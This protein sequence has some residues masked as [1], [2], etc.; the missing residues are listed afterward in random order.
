MEKEKIIFCIQKLNEAKGEDRE[1]IIA[2]FAR[3]NNLKVK[4]AWK[5]LIETGFDPKAKPQTGQSGGK[6]SLVILRHKTEFSRYRCAGLVLTQKAEPYE[7]TEGQLDVL[8]K[9][10]WVVIGEDKKDGA[11]S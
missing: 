5:I 11:G 7:V 3:E 6:K 4:D 2:E 1:T 8:K 10:F 9:D